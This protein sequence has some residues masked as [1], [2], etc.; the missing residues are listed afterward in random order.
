M[1]NA[2]LNT[3]KTALAIAVGATVGL[4][5]C[6]GGGGGAPV[7]T[8]PPNPWMTALILA[9]QAAASTDT[10]KEG[11]A[12]KRAKLLIAAMTLEPKMQQLTCAVPG[13]IPEF[14]NCKG[15]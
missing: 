9:E 7:A 1:R 12:N 15:G 10:A 14:P 11:V 8:V 2:Q 13:V 5:A 6:G 4:A 3:R